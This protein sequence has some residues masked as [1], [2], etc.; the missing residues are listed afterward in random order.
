MYTEYTYK[1]I[2]NVL[3]HDTDESTAKV[4]GITEVNGQMVAHFI[5][6]D[7]DIYDLI[8]HISDDRIAQNGSYDWLA[9]ITYGWAAPLNS[10]GVVDGAPSKHP[11]RRRVRLTVAVDAK[12]DHSV[13]SVLKFADEDD[14]IVDLGAATGSLADAIAGLFD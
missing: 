3:A 13:G 14:V 5:R 2:H 7:A 6:E 8:D 11:E 4:Y 12:N 10:D 1:N 9:F